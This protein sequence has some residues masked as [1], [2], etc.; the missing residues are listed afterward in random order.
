M[1]MLQRRSPT[2]NDQNPSSNDSGSQAASSTTAGNEASVPAEQELAVDYGAE[3]DLDP[4]RDLKVDD[5]IL[6]QRFRQA[7]DSDLVDTMLETEF[8]RHLRLCEMAILDAARG[9][10]YWSE[11]PQH[12]MTDINVW[13]QRHLEDEAGFAIKHETTGEEVALPAGTNTDKTVRGIEIRHRTTASWFGAK[14][15]DPDR[16][17][18]EWRRRVAIEDEARSKFQPVMQSRLEGDRIANSNAIWAAVLDKR[19]VIEVQRILHKNLLCLFDLTGRFLHQEPTNVAFSA[20]MGPDV[21]DVA[22]WETRAIE[23]TSSWDNPKST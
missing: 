6:F 9:T 8:K 11:L 16:V 14:E 20:M 18:R 13:V 3:P 2:M 12:P 1:R 5:V 21:G 19:Y 4:S 15:L 22:A 23:V 17:A 7:V 10:C